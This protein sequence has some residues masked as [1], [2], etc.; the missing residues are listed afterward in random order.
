MISLFLIIL[1]QVCLYLPLVFGAYI[2]ISLMK[3][4]D[5]SIESAYLFGAITATHYLLT[6]NTGVTFEMLPLT[7]LAALAGG[8]FVGCISSFLTQK[9]KIPHLLS[10]ILTG[11]LFHGINQMILGTSN[12]SLSK[13]QNYLTC[14]A[15]DTQ[16][17]ELVVLILIALFL[18]ICYYFFL[19]TQLGY[20]LA[21]YGN[22]AQFFKYHHISE[23]FVFYAGI[24]LANALA[25]L[26]GYLVALS[27]GFV[28]LTMNIGMSLFTISALILGKIII[29]PQGTGTYLV[30]LVGTGSYFFLQSLLLNLGFNLKY[31][32]MIQ[33]LIV[34]LFLG[35]SFKKKTSKENQPIDTLGV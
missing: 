24:L 8:M 18:C 25:G 27:T 13:A 32:T 5:L 7:M 22:N 17:S 30:P 31:F 16:H 33:A 4:P 12:V 19:K 29:Q 2:S 9:I 14:F 15:I 11:G 10:S 3:L 23:S 34:L 20:A 26:S 28:D 21:V 6:C 35:F 1:E